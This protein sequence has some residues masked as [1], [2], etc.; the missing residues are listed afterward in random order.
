M[1]LL[2][3]GYLDRLLKPF[4]NYFK[5]HSSKHELSLRNTNI[6]TWQFVITDAEKPEK[7]NPGVSESY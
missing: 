1:P 7:T 6:L 4:S 3:R 5:T 2:R